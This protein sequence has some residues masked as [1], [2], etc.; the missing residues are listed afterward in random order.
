MIWHCSSAAL[1]RKT[2]FFHHP[3]RSSAQVTAS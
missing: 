1:R 2:P 3:E